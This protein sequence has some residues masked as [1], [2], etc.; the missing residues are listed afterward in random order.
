M[1]R[2]VDLIKSNGIKGAIKKILTKVK[3]KNFHSQEKAF[4]KYHII[5]QDERNKQKAKKFDK[6]ITFSVLTPLYNTPKKYLIDMIKS[7][8]KQTYANWQLCLADASDKEHKYVEDICK[9]LAAKD[10]RITY[11]RL[12]KNEGISGNTNKC[13]ELARG[14]YIG[15]LDHDDILHESAL[16]EVMNAIEK[17]NAEFVYTDEI[18]F[19]NDLKKSFGANLKPDFSKY[20][21]RSHNFICHF[22]VFKK[23]LLDKIGDIYRPA[24]DGSQDHDMVLRLTEVAAKIEH[25]RKILYYW[26]VHP[27]SVSMNLDS[28]SYAV[29]AAINAIKDQLNRNDIK[30]NVKSNLPYRTMYKVDYEMPNDSSVAIVVTGTK[31]EEEYKNAADSINDNTKTSIIYRIY[32]GTENTNNELIEFVKNNCQE[33]YVVVIDRLFEITSDSWIDEIINPLSQKDVAFVSPKIVNASDKIA[34]A[35]IAIDKDKKYNFR[36]LGQGIDVK[37]EGYEAILN[38]LRCTTIPCKK[39]FAIK[40]DLIDKYYENES[41]LDDYAVADMALRC[42]S[43]GLFTIYEPYSVIKLN[44][45]IIDEYS[46]NGYKQFKE[47]W[48]DTLNKKDPFYHNLWG[49]IG[50]V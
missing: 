38:Y 9:K 5:S 20:E 30:G 39:C 3:N 49:E 35:G 1:N 21:L 26:R 31:D 32:R 22:T 14:E 13:L 37:E 50:L 12:E 45:E 16:Y 10:N 11:K 48:K 44:S 8:S 6:E 17:T 36:Y 25:I 18:K 23:D 15:L 19:T 40:K 47:N 29:D 24:F 4:S 41:D 43:V 46:E 27:Q 33:K 42:K 34:Y 28:K 7:L 2:I